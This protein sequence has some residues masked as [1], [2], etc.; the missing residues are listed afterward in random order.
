MVFKN[1]EVPG[2]DI[3]YL[4]WIK[5][6]KDESLDSYA[7]RMVVQIQ[8]ESPVLIGLSFGGIM[9][10]E[11]ARFIPAKLVII[12]SSI[13]N[14]REMPYWMRL[15]GKLRLNRLLPMRSFK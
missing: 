6:E 10:I 11:M 1:L 15:S 3:Y 5:P 7:R 9:C 8:H 13:K 14:F 12:I 2:Y 4:E